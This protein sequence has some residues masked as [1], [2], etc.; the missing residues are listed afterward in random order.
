MF[1]EIA[2]IICFYI[3]QS[4]HSSAYFIEI[5]C[6]VF[7]EMW[8][9]FSMLQYFYGENLFIL[10]KKLIKKLFNVVG[11]SGVNWFLDKFNQDEIFGKFCAS[12]RSYYQVIFKLDFSSRFFA[13]S[14]TWSFSKTSY[15]NI[16]LLFIIRKVKTMPHAQKKLH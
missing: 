16:F 5:K 8:I 10:K 13:S 2:F 3:L 1:Y 7:Y 11:G 14:N 9:V 6:E 15:L 12:L 4:Q